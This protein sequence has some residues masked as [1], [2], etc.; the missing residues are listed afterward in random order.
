ML[1]KGIAEQL[2]RY[3]VLMEDVFSQD[4][5]TASFTQQFT[6]SLSVK[7]KKGQKGTA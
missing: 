6:V 7:L 3:Y 4:L 1:L 2:N 5:F